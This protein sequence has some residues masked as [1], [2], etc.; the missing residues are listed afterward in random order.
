MTDN[1]QKQMVDRAESYG[2]RLAM[3][4]EQRIIQALYYAGGVPSIESK[5]EAK[6]ERDTDS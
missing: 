4:R 1:E 5:D 3:E 6:H 2:Y